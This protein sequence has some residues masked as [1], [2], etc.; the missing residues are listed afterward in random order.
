ML[1]KILYNIGLTDKEALVYLACIELGASPVSEIA[2]KA[3]INRVTTYDILDK[4]IHKGFVNFFNKQ[5]MRYFSATDPEIIS[6]ETARKAEDLRQALPKLKRLHG[7]TNHPHIQYF[8]GIAGIKAL[9]ADSLSSK[10]EILNYANSREIRDHWPE[11][12]HE[13]VQERVKRQIFLRGICPDDDYGKRVQSTDP[14]YYREIRL[15]PYAQFTFTNEI[16]IYDDK[17]AIS[18]FK[19]ELIGMIIQSQAIADTQRDIFKM[20]W[21]YAAKKT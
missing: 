3:G 12:D 11:Y 9:Y 16:N 10:T 20:A 19:N 18:S 17:V 1:K 2:E 14:E 7:S 8:E 4:L 6:Y 13:Y 21:E 15:V 5:K